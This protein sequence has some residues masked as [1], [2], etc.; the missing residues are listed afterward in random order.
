MVKIITDTSFSKETEE[1]LVLIDF[2]GTWCPPCKALLPV[3]EQI[4]EELAEKVKIVKIDVDES[5]ETARSFGVLSV[6]TMILK[7]N[8]EVVK[9]VT[10]FHNK[11]TLTELICDYI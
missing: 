7:K 10:G 2:F 6:P 8:N 9:R 11:S 1:G 5:P 3:L 4:E